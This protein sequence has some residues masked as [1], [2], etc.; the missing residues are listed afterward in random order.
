MLRLFIVLL[1]LPVYAPAL[2]AQP[3]SSSADDRQLVAG[4]YAALARGDVTAVVAVLDDHVV[5]V[6]EAPS[7]Q[8]GRYFGPG[9][10]ARA[11]LHPL[12][13]ADGRAAGVLEAVTYAGERVVAHGTT[14][15][16][17]PATGRLMVVRFRHVWQVLDGRVVHVHRAD[18]GPARSASDLCSPAPC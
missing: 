17:D 18:D 12:A 2:A 11:V 14:R 4:I 6:E 9:T 13:G 7:P 1:A 8:A 16:T 3:A 5:W 10:V 15:R